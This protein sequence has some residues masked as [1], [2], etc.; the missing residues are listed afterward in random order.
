MVDYRN[1]RKEFHKIIVVATVGRMDGKGQ[2]S[3]L[4]GQLGWGKQVSAR[5]V[6]VA[7]DKKYFRK[8][9]S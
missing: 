9:S 2:G 1:R 6:A 8:T 4:G 3:P 7:V 5:G